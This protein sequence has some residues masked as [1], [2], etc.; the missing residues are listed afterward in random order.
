MS[1]DCGSHLNSL[2]FTIIISVEAHYLA[3]E[4][5]LT[6]ILF[7][8]KRY[9]IFLPLQFPTVCKLQESRAVSYCG[10]R[11]TL[12]S[13]RHSASTWP[14]HF[15]GRIAVEESCCKYDIANNQRKRKTG[16]RILKSRGVYR[17]KEKLSL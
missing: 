11:V 16:S 13:H 6:V 8:L 5:L 10:T 12:T 4:R 7:I 15:Q 17:Y 2:L 9:V 3:I 14:F 1:L